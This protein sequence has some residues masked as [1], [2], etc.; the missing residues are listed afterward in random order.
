MAPTDAVSAAQAVWNAAL[1]ERTTHEWLCNDCTSSISFTQPAV[2]CPVGQRL[3][4]DEQSAFRTF[5]A[6]RWPGLAL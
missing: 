4:D 1:G 2:L 3:A 5:N 6:T